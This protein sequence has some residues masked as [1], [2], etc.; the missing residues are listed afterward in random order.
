ME[1]HV[2]TAAM[3]AMTISLIAGV[4]IPLGLFLVLRFRYKCKIVPFFVGCG[5]FLVFAMVLESLL[6]RAVLAGSLGKVLTE[7]I[8]LYGLYGALAAA[9]FEEVGRYISMRILH[10]RKVTDAGTGLMFGAGHGGFECFYILAVG[11]CSNLMVAA[12][13]YSDRLEEITKM[14]PADQ[15]EAFLMQIDVLASTGAAMF[16][17][18]VLERLIAVTGH[19]VM[20]VL[21]WRSVSAKGQGFCFLLAFAMHFAMDFAAVMISRF[22]GV[23]VTEL[24]IAIIVLAFL[25]LT[26]KLCQNKSAE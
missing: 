20:S 26:V 12:M 19:M 5:T 21:V 7:N 4:V 17:V 18:G 3:A 6:H 15:Q 11:M 10:A 16:L 25:L 8:W 23:A 13:V 1:Y 2:S 14:L 24:V 9:T 22:F